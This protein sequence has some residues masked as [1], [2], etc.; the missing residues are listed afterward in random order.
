MLRCARK[1]IDKTISYNKLVIYNENAIREPIFTNCNPL[2]LYKNQNRRTTFSHLPKHEFRSSSLSSTLLHFSIEFHCQLW[3]ICHV[4]C[5]DAA[6][7]FWHLFD[8][9]QPMWVIA[10]RST[11]R[12]CTYNAC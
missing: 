12:S 1:L 8:R 7:K 11:V 4:S 2:I 6:R 9:C 10:N 3:H 5:D